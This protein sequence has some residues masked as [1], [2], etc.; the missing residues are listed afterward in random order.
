M[1][2]LFTLPRAVAPI[3]VISSIV[4]SAAMSPASAGKMN[5]KEGCSHGG[6]GG[7]ITERIKNL[8]LHARP[9]PVPRVERRSP[10]T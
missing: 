9:E 6:C 4:F 7:R 8:E 5:G 2:V 3:L 10:M 1:N